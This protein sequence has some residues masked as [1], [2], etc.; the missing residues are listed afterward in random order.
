MTK[1]THDYVCQT[2]GKPAVYNLQNNWHLWDITPKG[3]FKHNDEWEADGNENNFWCEEC[4][5]KEA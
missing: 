4:Y 3:N 2:C 1:I 5:E